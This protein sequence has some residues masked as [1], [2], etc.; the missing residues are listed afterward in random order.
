MAGYILGMDGGSSKTH[1]ALFDL[2]GN[3]ISFADWGPTNH[4]CLK[5]GF[6]ELKTELERLFTVVLNNTGVQLQEVKK[7][8]FGMSGVDT[9]KQ[10][11]V[12]SEILGE[13][14]IRD[15]VLCNDAFLGVKA[16]S[17]TGAGICAINGSGCTVTGI[18]PDGRMQQIGGQGSLTGD[19]GGGAFLGMYVVSSVYDSLWKGGK[20]TA[21][22]QI[23]F[24]L[25]GI[26]SKQEYMEALTEAIGSGA[27]NIGGLSKILFTAANQADVLALQILEDMGREYA[28]SIHSAIHTL[29][30]SCSPSIDVILAGSV[31]VKGENPAA[32]N[33]IKDELKASDPELNLNITTLRQPPVAGA[34]I[35]ALEEAG[36]K[37]SEVFDH[38]AMQ[39]TPG[40]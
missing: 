35:W 17:R 27:L 8:V 19:K 9:G 14:G 11:S 23:L 39:F 6:K 37:I 3:R 12:L 24:E 31:F 38:V 13:L 33:K 15:F 32:I 34:V 7:A 10:H 1:C 4:E 2:D 30:F 20:P 36:V 16:G 29:N 5:G 25:L 26:K 21:M 40:G 28:R 18:D 22:T